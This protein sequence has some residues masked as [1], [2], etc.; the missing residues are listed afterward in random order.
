VK[1]SL[2]PSALGL[3]LRSSVSTNIW[4]NVKGTLSTILQT[5]IFV[6]IY[7]ETYCITNSFLNHSTPVTSSDFR[8]GSTF[9]ETGGTVHPASLIVQN[10]YYDYYTIDFDISVVRVSVVL[11]YAFNSSRNYL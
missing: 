8:A 1:S 5:I 7:K 3:N 4:D 11:H 9:R 6:Q 10:P 2:Q